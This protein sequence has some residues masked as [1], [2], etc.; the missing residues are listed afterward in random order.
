MV[1]APFVF[2]IEN[3]LPT[4]LDP[5]EAVEAVWVATARW[6]TPEK[7]RLRNVPGMPANWLFPAHDLNGVPV[8]GFTYRLV[9]DWLGLNPNH[10]AGQSVGLSA[11]NGVLKF[12][13]S[14][15]L[16]VRDDWKMADAELPT[17]EIQPRATAAVSGGI[18]VEQTIEHFSKPG[19]SFPSVS[20][21]EVQRNHVRV[22]GLEFEEY[23][24]TAI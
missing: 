21:I 22:V 16:I 2:A 13:I 8:W 1:V 6:R 11:A 24:I 4:V 18:P 17:T 3:E 10:A 15:G 5:E 19:S 20:A 23:L 7:H 14:E 9:M 12:L